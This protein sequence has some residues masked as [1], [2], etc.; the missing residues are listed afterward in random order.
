MRFPSILLVFPAAAFLVANACSSSPPAAATSSGGQQGLTDD[1]GAGST[2]DNHDTNPYG[3]AYP[4]ANVGRDARGTVGTAGTP[5]KT[6]GNVIANFKFLG[7]PG[8]DVS[9]GLQTIAMADFF[10]P[11]QKQ[12]SLIHLSVAG[13]W[14]VPCNEET[15]VSVTLV[16]DFLKEKV[17]FVQALGDG[18]IEGEGATTMDLNNWITKHK[19]NFTEML[20]PGLVNLGIFFDAAAIPWNA[21][22]DARSMELLSADVGY[23]EDSDDFKSEVQGWADWVNA[24]PPAYSSN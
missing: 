21:N 19:S 14:C 13:S 16:P 24:N 11:Q 23:S 8:G 18:P 3:V 6:P 4:T 10:D 12:Y 15:D 20:D 2:P 5:N 17:V 22:I 9:K 7:Y 1:A